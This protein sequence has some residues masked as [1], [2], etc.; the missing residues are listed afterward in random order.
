M[1]P[2]EPD[3]M[4][5]QDRGLGPVP[6]P[7]PQNK[8]LRLCPRCFWTLPKSPIRHFQKKINKNQILKKLLSDLT[9]FSI[10]GTVRFG[11]FCELPGKS[12]MGLET[13]SNKF[14]Y[15]KL[16]TI[17]CSHTS[18]VLQFEL[19]HKIMKMQSKKR[20][21]KMCSKSCWSDFL[22]MWPQVSR[23]ITFRAQPSPSIYLPQTWKAFKENIIYIGDFHGNQKL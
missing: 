18:R 16:Q 21:K 2:C 7:V 15:L 5:K 6:A 23:D 20:K 17:I 3:W 9:A 4:W 1:C 10:K 12:Q 14:S 19:D 11:F 13:S 22:I 8:G